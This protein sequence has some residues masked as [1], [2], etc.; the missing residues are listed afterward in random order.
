MGSSSSVV[1]AMDT[2]DPNLRGAVNSTLLSSSDIFANS[3]YRDLFVKYMKEGEWRAKLNAIANLFDTPTD[4]IEFFASS[5]IYSVFIFP[6]SLSDISSQLIAVA[7][8]NFSTEND[9]PV[10][11]SKNRLK[12]I[13]IGAIFLIFLGSE[14]YFDMVQK[15]GSV[16]LPIKS[17]PQASI[18]SK[19]L[20][21]DIM[22]ASIGIDD[23]EL[24][25]LLGSGRWMANIFSS[26]ENL[27]FCVTLASADRKKQP[28]F[29]LLYVNK[30]F[31]KMTGYNRS[32]IL[33][34][35]CRFLQGEH[36]EKE[37]I[38]LMG[39][40]LATAQPVKAAITNRRKDGSGVHSK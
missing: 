32:D 9:D 11:V 1:Q 20:P 17:F 23:D 4:S 6:S 37:Q 13:L 15:A 18:E 35:N 19:S 33:G 12:S 25:F 31:E 29:P 2:V 39:Q 34:K 22:K 10:E 38:Q 36:S 30:A 27:R 8:E 7:S 16:I 5:S 14:D 3:A 26:I 40:A 28:G 24:D 21:D